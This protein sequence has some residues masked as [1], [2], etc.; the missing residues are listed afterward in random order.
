MNIF[1]MLFNYYVN[2]LLLRSVV[3]FLLSCIT[4]NVVG[5]AYIRFPNLEENDKCG[6]SGICK[7]ARDCPEVTQSIPKGQ[8]PQLCGFDVNIPLI[9]CPNKRLENKS[10]INKRIS[11]KMCEDYHK[12]ACPEWVES[13]AGG[14]D[15]APKELPF[16]AMVGYGISINSVEWLCAGSL[17]S[18]KYVLSAAHCSDTDKGPARWVRLGELD[19]SD[20][21]DDAAPEDYRIIKRTNHPRYK[22]SQNYYDI[23][24]FKLHK[25]V[26][27]SEYI[28]PI[29][30]NQNFNIDRNQ[31]FTAAGWGRP[32]IAE[33]LS[34]KLQKVDLDVF[35]LDTCSH[36]N[37]D[38]KIPNGLVDSM[39]CAGKLEE[40]KDT[41]T[42]DSGGPLFH[43][44]KSKK[45]PVCFLHVQIGITSFGPFEC[46][47]DGKPAIYT[48]VVHYLNWIEDILW[49][50][51]SN[52][53]NKNTTV[54]S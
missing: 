52:E 24:L 40:E 21:N 32:K 2:I 1:N 26:I 41:C 3:L 47:L 42:G 14:V 25:D 43:P 4:S 36:F 44:P 12:K 16:M 5:C 35:G 51:N 38:V 46:G 13:I 27:F 49:P 48:S 39:I 6:V 29:C 17:I 23:A 45:T 31:I 8:K 19:V 11:E 34:K 50:S 30:L 33:P 9:C 22:N 18:E 7:K 28:K 20:S 10:P 53:I 15:A 37:G 54:W